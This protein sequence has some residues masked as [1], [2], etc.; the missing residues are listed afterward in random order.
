M[1]TPKWKKDLR[2]KQHAEAK[3]RREFEK[4]YGLNTKPK[5]TEQSFVPL[6]VSKPY[7]RE[8]R[9]IPSLSTSNRLPTGACPPPERKVYTGT[10]IKGIA[11]MHKSN[12]VPIISDEHAKEIA[13]MRRG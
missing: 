1:S 10:L 11:T 9:E 13:R 4:K 8:T 6:T 2:Q 3:T 7:I 12:A 5:K